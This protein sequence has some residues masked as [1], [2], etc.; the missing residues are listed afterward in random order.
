MARMVAVF[1]P[2]AWVRDNAIDVDVEGPAE[3]DVTEFFGLLTYGERA[4]M[5]SENGDGD[6]DWLK[7]DPAAP[8]WVQTWQGPFEIHLRR[9]K[10]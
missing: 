5:L 6:R 3:W 4:R 9:E 10:R 7:E 2:Q 1:T 8:Q